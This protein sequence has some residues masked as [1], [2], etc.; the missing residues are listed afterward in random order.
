MHDVDRERHDHVAR[1]ENDNVAQQ[2]T[3][4]AQPLPVDEAGLETGRDRDARPDQY[5]TEGTAPDMTQDMSPGMTQDMEQGPAPDMARDSEQ[6][7][8]REPAMDMTRDSARR[9]SQEHDSELFNGDTVTR[10]RA[11]WR[12]LQA[13]FVDDPERAVREADEVVDEVVRTITD[14][15]QRLAGEWQG[16]TDTEHLRLAMREYRTFVD[17]LLPTT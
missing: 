6:E 4:A 1:Q 16:H 2:E 15:R 5:A 7:P 8:M 12:E 17:H 14:Q 3:L 11:R 10:L 9:D 13:D